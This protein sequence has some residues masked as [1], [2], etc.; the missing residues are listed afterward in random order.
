V[1]VDA[2]KCDGCRACEPVCPFA[3]TQFGAD[4]VLQLCD[5]CSDRLAE[6]KRPICADSCPTQALKWNPRSG[7]V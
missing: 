1:I 5:L 6:G 7:A 4:G 2:A 3:L